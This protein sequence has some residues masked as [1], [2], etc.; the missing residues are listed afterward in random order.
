[1]TNS[2][3]LQ[4]LGPIVLV[5]VEL[6]STAVLVGACNT[7][8]SPDQQ[9]S[10]S[11]ITTRVKAKL[12]SDLRASSLANIDVN[13]TNGVV[14]LSGQ[15]ENAQVKQGAETVAASVAGVARVNDDLQVAPTGSVDR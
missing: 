9:I 8:Q 1:M 6:V 13:T 4:K 5:M 14:T 12:A 15:V 10:D 11:Q 7:S 2:K 3:G